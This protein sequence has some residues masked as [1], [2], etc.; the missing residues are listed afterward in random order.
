MYKI[1][2]LSTLSTCFVYGSAKVELDLEGLYLQRGGSRNKVL[3]AQ[4]DKPK[5]I[6]K[7]SAHKLAARLGY[8]PG[9][10]L[11]LGASGDQYGG[12]IR[13]LVT[14]GWSTTKKTN[15]TL[16]KFPFK[17]P[18][19]AIEWQRGYRAIDKY[20]N[21]LTV[22]DAYFSSVIAPIWKDY[23]GAKYLVGLQYFNLPEDNKLT[24]YSS[25]L[26]PFIGSYQVFNTYKASTTNDSLLAA[27]G[28]FFQMKPLKTL[29]FELIGYGGLGANYSTSHTKLKG[30]NDTIVRRSSS[31]S[32]IGSAYSF[33]SSVRLTYRPYD[34]FEISGSYEFLC[35]SGM[36]FA[37]RQM[38]YGSKPTSDDQVSRSG[39]AN[40]QGFSLRIG[41]R[42]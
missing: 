25:L 4:G 2:I 18:T 12:F 30:Y 9:F 36:A 17:D 5:R 20:S 8:E 24:M 32:A 14:A 3:V 13:A 41:F 42:V 38:S 23:F 15:G 1:F 11:T 21:N 29:A 35:I 22:I 39:T 27:L 16:L 40:F 31:E 28:F 10:R 34:F 19:Y 7:I 33:L 26:N 6:E 37:Y